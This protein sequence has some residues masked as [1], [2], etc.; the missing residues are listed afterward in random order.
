MSAKKKTIIIA[1]IAILVVAFIA[2]LLFLPRRKAPIT[3][4]KLTTTV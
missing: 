4:R 3:T 2:G 1:V